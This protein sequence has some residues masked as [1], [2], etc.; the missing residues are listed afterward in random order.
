MKEQRDWCAELHQKYNINI[1]EEKET[2][3]NHINN[4]IDKMP[5]FRYC[6]E[7]GAEAIMVEHPEAHELFLKCTKCDSLWHITYHKIIKTGSLKSLV[8]NRVRIVFNSFNSDLVRKQK[9]LRQL[10]RLL[11]E[12]KGTS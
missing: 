10:D 3:N 9:A 1:D 4:E 7:C 6:L 2:I 5:I 12:Y 8:F 11:D